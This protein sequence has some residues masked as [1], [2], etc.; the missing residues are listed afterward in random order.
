[1]RS[2]SL[3]LVLL[4]ALLLGS[5]VGEKSSTEEAPAV[6]RNDKQF[7]R[8]LEVDQTPIE[9]G[10]P[11]RGFFSDQ[12][13]WMGFTH[14]DEAQ[15]LFGFCGPFSLRSYEWMAKSLTNITLASGEAAAEVKREYFP[16]ILQVKG[17]FGDDVE[18]TQELI[19]ADS[20][21]ALLRVSSSRPV[22]LLLQG[23]TLAAEDI[24]LS[25][26]GLQLSASNERLY[27]LLPEE[28]G[29]VELYEGGYQ[30]P[31]TLEEPTTLAIVQDRT[32]RDLELVRAMMDDSDK[33]FADNEVRWDGYLSAVLREGMPEGFDRIAAKSI[34]TLI[35]N[36]VAPEGDL[37]YDGI[38]PSHAKGYF[39]GLWA[40]DTW[41]EAVATA[42]FAPDLAK[43]LIYSMLVFQD[44]LGMVADCVY[45][46]ASENNWRN[47]KA[48]LTAWAVE[49]VYKA[50]GDKEFLADV[51]PRLV[52]YHNWW[53]DY[54]DVD[55]NGICEFGSTDGT[56]IAAA[57]ESGMD[58]AVRF[59]HATMLP[60][61]GGQASLDQESVD[62][63]AFLI[64]ERELLAAF[65][66][67]L[68]E[69]F[70][71]RGITVAEFREYFFDPADG[72]Y[73]DRKVGGGDFIRVQGCEAYAPL[74]TE[75]ASDDQ[76]GLMLPLL[77]DEQKFATHV[78]FPTLAADHP[79]YAYNG[80]WR[81]PIWVD[82]SYFAIS[83]LRRYG[84]AKLA[85]DYTEQLFEHLQGAK[86]MGPL[87]ENY[88]PLTGEQLQAR[89]FSWTAAHLLFMYK[90][91]QTT[92]DM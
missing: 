80:Y 81:G 28:A 5:C 21:V 29:A 82:Q 23:S 83:G 27:L 38:I 67:I 12:G 48:P 26:S 32:H 71:E 87:C 89:H 9:A 14:P 76:F 17:V 36:W 58:N 51:F 35:S 91:Y 73:Y 24:S 18:V 39:V 10:E 1:M 44:E 13:S 78:P 55:G 45:A 59:D 63:N 25:T 85:D 46:D 57:W 19:F 49:A 15:E 72:F 31:I 70:K 61:K 90:E 43:E 64:L 22:D 4:G 74:W 2:K 34:V 47:T 84:E 88:D 69:P 68:D 86:E 75:L 37:P 16:G 52:K 8:I 56:R 50:T 3:S 11:L 42:M 62:L 7:S 65:A 41:K 20:E 77:N 79:G 40:W 6:S 33:L 54:R 92:P 53:Y 60:T 30:V 66:K